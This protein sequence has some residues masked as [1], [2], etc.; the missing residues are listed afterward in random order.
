MKNYFTIKD[1]AFV[2]IFV[3]YIFVIVGAPISQN[4]IKILVLFLLKMLLNSNKCT[5]AYLECKLR[6]VEREEGYLNILLSGIAN[7]KD[8]NEV[9]FGIGLIMYSMSLSFGF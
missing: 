6:N 5:F 2:Y 8:S 4:Y 1:L 9:I 3:G 7:L